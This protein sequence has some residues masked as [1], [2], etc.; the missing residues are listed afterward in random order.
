MTKLLATTTLLLTLLVSPILAEALSMDDLV[1]RDGLYYKK[2]TDVP[3]TGEVFGKKKGSLKS[4]K[5]NGKWTTYYENGVKK[6]V[7][8]F[9]ND[10]R[11]EKSIKEWG[12]DGSQVISKN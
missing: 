7:I 2:F 8:R 4:G 10:I 12:V 3:F 6:S 9:I 5:K 11:Q 1:K